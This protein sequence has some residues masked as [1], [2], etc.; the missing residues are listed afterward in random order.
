MNQNTV[1]P[2]LRHKPFGGAWS[3]HDP[4]CT[5]LL[6]QMHLQPGNRKAFL[7]DYHDWFSNG[8]DLQGLSQYQHI[9]FV[10]GTTETFHMFYYRHM[11]RRLRLFRD[12]YFYHH[13]MRRNY[14]K[15]YAELDH[16][17]LQKNDV[18]VMSCPFSGHGGVPENFYDILE[19]CERLQ[20]PVMLDMA[21]I[22]ISNIKTINLNYKCIETITTSLSKIFPVENLRIGIRLERHLYDDPVHAY[23]Q[24]DYVNL[25]SIHAGHQLIK[26]FDNQ[27]LYKKYHGAQVELCHTLGVRPSQCVIFG[28]AKR[29]MF[30]EYNRG[31]EINRLCFSKVW[32]RRTD[33]KHSN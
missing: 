32:D 25:Q 23:N 20:V 33:V 17:T 14:F 13:M 7:Q 30:D 26:K 1:L 28:I 24:N 2:P 16:K 8:I 11:D 18:V 4:E 21:Y 10:A 29:G 5:S 3:I 6:A 22:N 9:D 12:E 27:W 15:N 31:G 19:S